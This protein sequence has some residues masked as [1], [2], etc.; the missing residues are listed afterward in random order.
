[1]N[2]NIFRSNCSNSGGGGGGGSKKKKKGGGGGGGG[3]G[4]NCSAA[5]A[6]V[7]TRT[8]NTL[9][10][11]IGGKNTAM[12]GAVT[13]SLQR[14]LSAPKLTFELIDLRFKLAGA[15]DDFLFDDFFEQFL[16]GALSQQCFVAPLDFALQLLEQTRKRVALKDDLL[17]FEC[18]GDALGD[19]MH[20]AKRFLEI[21]G[22]THAHRF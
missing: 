6:T 9:S 22:R 8:R 1:M 13:L 15:L 5:K 20:V 19:Q 11:R 12:A 3:G 18:A 7:L 2:F 14:C 16:V 10:I 21:V 17:L 4:G